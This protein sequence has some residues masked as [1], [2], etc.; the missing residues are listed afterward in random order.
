MEKVQNK[1]PALPTLNAEQAIHGQRIAFQDQ[2]WFL[3]E[4]LIPADQEFLVLGIKKVVQRW[5]GNKPV[6]PIVEQPGK[7]LPDVAALNSAIPEEQW[8]LGPDN[9]PRAPWSLAYAVYLLR[10][11][12]AQ[13]CTSINGTGGQRVAAVALRDA[14]EWMAA[15]KQEFV[16]PVVTLGAQLY[17]KRFKKYRP[18][19]AI[20]RWC[21]FGGDGLTEVKQLT[22]GD[23]GEK[24]EKPTLAEEMNDAIPF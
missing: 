18:D 24:V 17:S 23:V 19:Y 16:W 21:R 3:N 14:I 2:K 8:P 20:V 12:G 1:L 9:Q 7:D 13:I 11:P 5:E 4:I 6:D 10:L 15:L 22:A